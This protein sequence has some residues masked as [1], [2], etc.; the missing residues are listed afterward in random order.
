MNIFL[1]RTYGGLLAPDTSL[2]V[3]I[4][5]ARATPS[6]GSWI[7]VMN[8]VSSGRVHVNT[9]YLTVNLISLQYL[10]KIISGKNPAENWDVCWCYLFHFNDT[11]AFRVSWCFS[12]VSSHP[13][14]HKH[15][16]QANWHMLPTAKFSNTWRRGTVATSHGWT[17]F[18][19]LWVGNGGWCHDK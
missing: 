8:L 15:L 5:A 11:L 13:Q 3:Y 9:L 2:Q 10:V 4:T 14:P 19:Q 7:A 6:V 16:S 12:W 1:S 17:S 18:L